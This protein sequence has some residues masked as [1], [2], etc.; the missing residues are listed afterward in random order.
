MTSLRNIRYKFNKRGIYN[1]TQNKK[2]YV[3]YW[4]I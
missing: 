2:F 4:A 3:F 1:E